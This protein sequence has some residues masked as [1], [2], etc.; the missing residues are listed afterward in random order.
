MISTLSR[1]SEPSAACLMCSGRLFRPAPL[2][3]DYRCRLRS[4]PNLVAIT[5]CSRNGA[6][7][8]PTSSSLSERAVDFGGVEE[9]DAAFHGGAEK[10]DHLLLVFG[11]TVGKAHSH[12]AE[13]EGRDFQI[14]FSKFALLHNASPQEEV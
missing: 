13:P 4:K 9:G 8:S 3:A 5:T 7:A 1:L 10:R 2:P 6:S 12:A 14:A 11:R